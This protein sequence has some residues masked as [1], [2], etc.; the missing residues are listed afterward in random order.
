MVDLKKLA[1]ALL[2]AGL[3]LLS[4]TSAFAAGTEEGAAGEGLSG[5]MSVHLSNYTPGVVRGEGLEKLV[6][7]QEIVDEYM[8]MHPGVSIEI[9]TDP[10]PVLEWVVTQL[11]GGTAPDILSVKNEWAYQYKDNNW[12]VDLMPYLQEPKPVR[13]RQRQVVGPVL[14]GHPAAEGAVQ[15]RAVRTLHRPGGHRLGLQQGDFQRARPP[16]AQQLERVLRDPGDAQGC[17]LH[18]LPDAAHRPAAGLDLRAVLRGH[19]A[20]HHRADRRRTEADSA[21]TRRSPARCATAPST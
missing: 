7:A 11:S 5:E 17:R 9:R 3:L 18:T 6:E 13:G 15:R 1:P 20:G 2:S 14:R 10:E 19:G 21:T 8:Q 4:G 12:F 16:G